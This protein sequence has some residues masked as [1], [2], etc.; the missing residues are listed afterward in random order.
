MWPGNQV[1]LFALF[2]E[3]LVYVLSTDL[4][5]ETLCLGLEHLAYSDSQT[6]LFGG[7]TKYYIEI[8]QLN[9]S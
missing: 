3:V 9:F 7:F 5:P 2:L 4:L 8:T 1:E 6:Q